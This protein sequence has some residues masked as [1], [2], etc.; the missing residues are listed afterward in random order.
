MMIL[1]LN[2]RPRLARAV[3]LWLGV[4]SASFA[5]A[6]AAGAGERIAVNDNRVAAGTLA[7]GTLTVRLETRTGDWYPDGDSQPCVTVKAF[8]A[9][10]QPLQ[11]PGPVV[12][13]PEGTVIHL[14]LRNRLDDSLALHGLYS[15]PG[16][17]TDLNP[18]VVPAGESR[19]VTFLAGRVGTYYYWAAST[20]ATALP[21]RSG[22]ESQ[23]SGA[24]IV[25]PPDGIPTTIACS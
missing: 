5:G 22:V 12:R 15:R 24:L 10:G 18:L 16:K 14:L 9:E 21:D 3:A 17:G 4:I 1:N 6:S 2:L 8:A 13:V 11:I 19:E 7:N 23:L 25:D 20:V